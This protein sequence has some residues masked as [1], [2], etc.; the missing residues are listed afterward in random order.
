MGAA[1]RGVMNED[2]DADDGIASTPLT[3]AGIGASAGG[4]RALQDFFSALP[5]KTGAALVVVMHLA[6]DHQSDLA[7]IIAGRTR[8]SVQQVESTATLE[9]DC[10]YVVPPNRQ[11]VISEDQLSAVEF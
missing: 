10:V 5:E 7:Q 2:S 4:V 11:L 8:M 9:P 6:P 1:K 3:I